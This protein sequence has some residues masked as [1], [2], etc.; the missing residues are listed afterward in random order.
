MISPYTTFD[1]SSFG[2]IGPYSL[3][4]LWWPN[5]EAARSAAVNAISPRV[6]E[7][8]RSGAALTRF[9]IY[10]PYPLAAR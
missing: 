7:T 8:C 3:N 4:F 6:N 10:S 2:R 1:N 9:F 5:V